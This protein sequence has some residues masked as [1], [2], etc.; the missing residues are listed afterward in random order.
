MTGNLKLDV[1]LPEVTPAE[2]EK[3]RREL[4]LG[5][6]KIL[7][8]ASTWPGEDA[9]LLEAWR[10]LGADTAGWKLLIVPRHAERRGEIEALLA[11]LRSLGPAQPR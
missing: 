8:G 1:T 4:G 10:G 7:L 5:E 6:A 3:V 9:S 2:A 11:Y